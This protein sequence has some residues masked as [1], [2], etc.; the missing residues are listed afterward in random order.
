MQ[1]S[2]IKSISSDVCVILEDGFTF[3][4]QMDSEG[5]FINDTT[6]NLYISVGNTV[7]HY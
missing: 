5:T 6:V 2:K 7:G 3:Y 1:Y 4:A